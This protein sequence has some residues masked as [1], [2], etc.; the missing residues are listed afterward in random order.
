MVG[1]L[2]AS[3]LVRHRTGWMGDGLIKHLAYG[4][5]A[6]GNSPKA[7]KV[8]QCFNGSHIDGLTEIYPIM[9]PAIPPTMAHGAPPKALARMAAPD[10]ELMMLLPVSLKGFLIVDGCYC[11]LILKP[12]SKPSPLCSGAVALIHYEGVSGMPVCNLNWP[13][14]YF[15]QAINH[16]NARCCNGERLKNFEVG[17]VANIRHVPLWYLSMVTLYSGK[18]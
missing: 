11:V 17:H 5:S 12:F 8:A 16:S 7:D 10:A 3:W 1:S 14:E 13:G 6:G 4:N 2:V 9:A 15:P 18:L